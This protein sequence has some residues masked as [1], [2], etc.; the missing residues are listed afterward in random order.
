MF[1]AEALSQPIRLKRLNQIAIQQMK[2]L[3]ADTRIK[4]LPGRNEPGNK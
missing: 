4:R 3:T 1:I 2:L